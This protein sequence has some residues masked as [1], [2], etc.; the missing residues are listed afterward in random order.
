MLLLLERRRWRAT[1]MMAR[2]VLGQAC[3]AGKF[4]TPLAKPPMLAA[5]EPLKRPNEQA[6]ILPVRFGVKL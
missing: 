1:W 5:D 2:S 4:L 6:P 3:G